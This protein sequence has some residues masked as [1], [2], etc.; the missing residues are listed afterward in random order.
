MN[1]KFTAPLCQLQIN[2]HLNDFIE[3]SVLEY[4]LYVNVTY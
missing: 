3:L 4:N 1:G 2:N